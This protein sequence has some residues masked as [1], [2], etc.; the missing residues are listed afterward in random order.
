MIH[1]EAPIPNIAENTLPSQHICS[2]FGGPKLFF[3][4]ATFFQVI[5]SQS[6][7][8][9]EIEILRENKLF[10]AKLLHNVEGWRSVSRSHA[11]D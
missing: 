8:P 2:F 9:P 1:H 11:A 3:Q 6:P 10:S 4:V 5:L 7:L